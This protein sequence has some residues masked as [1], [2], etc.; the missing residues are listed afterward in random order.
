MEIP[1]VGKFLRKFR[2]HHNKTLKDVAGSIGASSSFVSQIEKGI[3]NP[4]DEILFK[5]LTKA[6]EVDPERTG[7]IIKKWR[8]KQYSDNEMPKIRALKASEKGEDVELPEGA[9]W[10]DELP[11]LPYYKIITEEFDYDKPD[12]Y[13]PFFVEDPEMLDKLFIWQMYDNSMEP[14]IPKGSI[15]I[16]NKEITDPD[17]HSLVLAFLGSKANIRYYEKHGERVKLIPANRQYPVF[18][19][20]DVKVFGKVVKMLTDIS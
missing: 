12:A 14:D 5:V 8:I 6:F 9:A 10:I 19:G 1:P 16:I 11:L 7:D 13:W 17:Y 3:R 15:L 4:S 18:F 20:Q 2:K